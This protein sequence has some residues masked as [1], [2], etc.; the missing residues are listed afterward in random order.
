MDLNALFGNE[1]TFNEQ[2][3]VN[4]CPDAQNA[5]STFREQKAQTLGEMENLCNCWLFQSL[6]FA[7]YRTFPKNVFE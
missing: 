6:M 1:V 7:M 4:W 3:N 2:K 5:A